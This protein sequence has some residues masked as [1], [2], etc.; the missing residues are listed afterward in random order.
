LANNNDFEIIDN[1]IMEDKNL[2]DDDNLIDFNFSVLSSEEIEKRKMEHKLELEKKG[3][4]PENDDY[5]ETMTSPQETVERNPTRYIIKE[6]LP[7]CYE[8][9]KKNIY[10]FMVSD[11]LNEGVCWIEIISDDLSEENIKVYLEM[12]DDE[13]IK[14]SYHKGAINF[15]VNCVGIEGQAKLLELA[16]RFQMQ[17]VPRTRAY[18]LPQEFLMEY[19]GCYDEYINPDYREMKSPWELELYGQELLDYLNKYDEW[20]NSIYS[21]KMLKKFAQDKMTK[22][23]DDYV[24]EK[25]M[26]LDEGRI[27]LNKFHHDKH[28]KYLEYV[29]KHNKSNSN[30]AK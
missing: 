19:C 4:L 25:G 5:S 1:T 2:L 24:K 26:I 13:A 16:Q 9:W 10:T 18:L 17:D 20:E 23:L 7:A 12:T 14:F 6:C 21:K 22:S 27:Y 29:L 8:L 28:K 30:I 15:G 3:F 11:Y